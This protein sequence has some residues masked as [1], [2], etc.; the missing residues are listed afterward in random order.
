MKSRKIAAFAATTA[1]LVAGLTPWAQATNAGSKNGYTP[2]G[3]CSSQWQAESVLKADLT[4]DDPRYPNLMVDYHSGKT[5]HYSNGG[6]IQEVRPEYGYGLNKSG[7]G[8]F[9]LNHYYYG[10]GK[11]FTQAWRIPLATDYFIPKGTRILI[12]LPSAEL[13]F[14]NWKFDP[15]MG[16]SASRSLPDYM[17][18]WGKPYTNYTWNTNRVSGQLTGPNTVVVTLNKDLKPGE[19]TM[20]GVT[21][22]SVLADGQVPDINQYFVAKATMKYNIDP[23]TNVDD[24]GNAYPV[25]NNT[26]GSER[27]KPLPPSTQVPDFPQ[28]PKTNVCQHVLLGRTVWGPFSKDID[29][30]MKFTG[31]FSGKNIQIGEV[32]ADG[33]G[34]DRKVPVDQQTRWLRVYGAVDNDMIGGTYTVKATQGGK[35]VAAPGSVNSPAAGALGTNGYKQAV[36]GLGTVDI[37]EDGTKLT[38]KIDEMPAKSGFSFNVQFKMDGSK[39]SEARYLPVVLEHQLL[40][41]DKTCAPTTV[42]GPWTENKPNCENPEVEN[43]RKV[44][45]TEYKW[46]NDTKVWEKGETTEKVEPRTDKLTE[47]ELAACPKPEPVKPE[48]TPAPTPAPT[49]EPTPAPTPAPTVE[50][51]PAPTPAPTVEPTPAPTPAPTVEPTPAPTP[52]PTVEPTPAPTPAPTVEPT[53]APTPAPTVEP[54][55][56]PTPAP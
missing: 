46:N 54:T 4:N 33:W 56:A 31:D 2:I 28:V 40:I 24:Q 34:V 23:Y 14:G 15:K 9:E 38:L 16:D 8:M 35:F 49:V 22:T 48:P 30:R 50:P 26:D 20:F 39:D 21:G 19:A 17:A 44:T 1:L 42:E 45:T 13:G 36:K 51:T 29:N 10:S 3:E 6:Y 7:P 12:N 27:C 41:S 37:S 18:L 47:E 11:S 43:T 5:A 52:A 53:P 25:P 55:P 32:N